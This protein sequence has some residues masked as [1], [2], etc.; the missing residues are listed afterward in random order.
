LNNANIIPNRFPFDLI[1]YIDTNK[2]N[3]VFGTK[4]LYEAP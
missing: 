2:M 4:K 3:P 1:I